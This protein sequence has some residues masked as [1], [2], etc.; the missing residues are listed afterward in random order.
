MTEKPGKKDPAVTIS[1]ADRLL[2]TTASPLH[3]QILEN[4]RRHA[5]LEVTGQWEDIFAPDMTVPEPTYTFDVTGFEG[6]KLTGDEVKGFYKTLADQGATVILV[7]DEQLMVSDWGLASESWFSTYQRGSELTGRDP[8]GY[9]VTRQRL[10]MMWPFD[11]RGRL[12]GEHVYEAKVFQ[13]VTEVAEGD[14]VTLADAR[15]RLLPLLRPLP[16]FA[17]DAA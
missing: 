5:I 15:T 17:P 8:D 9:Y 16:K 3:R 1:A 13:Q 6:V 14:F 7:E 2:A 11:A 4:Y 12:V 10:A